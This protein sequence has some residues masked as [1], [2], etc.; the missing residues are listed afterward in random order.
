MKKIKT[1][2][3]SFLIVSTPLFAGSIFS[4]GGVGLINNNPTGRSAGMGILGVGYMDTSEVGSL[5]PAHW[6]GLTLS[7]F[8]GGFA[9]QHFSSKDNYA[10][11]SSDEFALQYVALGI[12]LK[13]NLGI[14]FRFFPQSRIDFRRFELKSAGDFAYSDFNIGKGGISLASAIIGFSVNDY[15]F[16]VEGDMLFGSMD[17]LWGV[18]FA[19]TA[20]SDAQ[21]TL[22]NRLFAVRPK[23][24]F[25]YQI[26][27]SS[28]IGIF[29][30]MP[31]DLDITQEMVY[32]YSDSTTSED[33]NFAYPA[34]IAVGY[35]YTINPRTI[36][37]FDFMWTGWKRDGQEIG[38]E[39]Q[40]QQSQFLA[41]GIEIQPL[42]GQ[43]LPLYKRLYYRA[44]VNIQNLY[45]RSPNLNSVVDIS[46]SLGIGIPFKQKQSSM[47]V[48]FTLGKRGSL[49]V[50]NAEEIY[51][52]FGIYIN[53]SEKWFVR[54]KK[55]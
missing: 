6:G 46:L 25:Q 33:I 30:A 41:A 37:C 2:L 39:L 19:S 52:N 53:T 20:I 48:A 10:S 42:N 35:K 44:G 9:I 15:Y 17:N 38:T 18:D 7:R 13:K 23:F 47:D 40:Y 24:G 36:G 51:A 34:S 5:N 3:L 55:Y 29:A 54:T 31:V 49:S 32:T 22:S 45:Y 16:G 14:G 43:L 28:S 26:N 8:S 11:D 12:P 50:N 21:F 1:T 4:G 27:D